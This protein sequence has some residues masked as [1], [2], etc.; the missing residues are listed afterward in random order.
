MKLSPLSCPEKVPLF[1]FFLF[2]FTHFLWKGWGGGQSSAV[3]CLGAVSAPVMIV[4]VTRE[5]KGRGSDVG[6]VPGRPP[7][8]HL[9]NKERTD[10]GFHLCR[11]LETPL[12]TDCPE[13][14]G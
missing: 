1:F 14:L 12:I 6:V 8:P 13:L 2:S 9:G 4:G 3:G 11:F 10:V 7:S 5:E